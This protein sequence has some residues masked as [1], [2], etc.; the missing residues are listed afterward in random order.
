M[1]LTS[2]AGY[3][4]ERREATRYW[5]IRK[6]GRFYGRTLAGGTLVGIIDEVRWPIRRI[7]IGF[8]T[9]CWD[10]DQLPQ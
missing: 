6:A 4:G 8:F 1:G 9:P 3:P 7:A 10:A 5:P 2:P